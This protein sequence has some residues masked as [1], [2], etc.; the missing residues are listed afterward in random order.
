MYLKDQQYM[1]TLAS[2]GSFT[3]AAS[4]LGIS[5]PALSKWLTGIESELGLT[6]VLRRKRG[7]ILTEAGQIYLDGCRM[8]LSAAQ[9]I[10]DSIEHAKSSEPLR[11]TCITLGGSPIRGADCFAS[12]YVPFKEKFADTDLKFIEDLAPNLRKRILSDEITLA[13]IGSYSPDTPDLEYLKFIDEE[14]LF[15][16]PRRSRLGYAPDARGTL[17]VIDLHDIGDFPLLIN[18]SGTSYI[19]VIEDIYEEHGLSRNIVFRNDM[20]PVLYKLVKSGVGAA[21][22]PSA[23]YNPSDEVSVY[24]YSPRIIVNQGIGIRRD[25]E[26]S[27]AEEY[28]IHLIISHWNAPA[29]MHQY[30]DYFFTQRKLRFS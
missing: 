3:A 17:P 26:L 2:C 8:A 5:Q 30:A 9:E 21:F 29:Y 6:L 27:A 20:V 18:S 7:I 16:V 1:N 25:R 10:K 13:I 11:Q 24:R 4:Q 23:Y 12:V 22:I 14:L 15:M 28:L 19:K